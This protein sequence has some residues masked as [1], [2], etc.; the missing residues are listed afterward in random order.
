MPKKAA[1]TAQGG[2]SYIGSLAVK[3][4]GTRL[5]HQACGKDGETAMVGNVALIV[6]AGRGTRFGGAVPK[7]YLPLA[8][9]SLLSHALGI[10]A[11]HHRIQAAGAVIHED[12]RAL[13]DDAARGL[14]LLDPVPGGVD[15]QDSVRLGLESLEALS[16]DR[17]LIQDGARPFTSEAVID[18]VLD[19]L[20]T[21]PG[22]IPGL[23]VTDTLKRVDGGR[24]GATQS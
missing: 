10:F 7:Q 4:H 8:G 24:I 12:D 11:R 6:A 23:P 19:A 13:Y 2:F 17:V 14:E 5:A 20:D 9:R 21:L 3:P 22:A 15:R 1:N 18:R 16:P